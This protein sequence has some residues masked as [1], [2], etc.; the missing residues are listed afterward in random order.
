MSPR[1]SE[2]ASGFELV[3]AAR[4]AEDGTG[5]LFVVEREG[6]IRIIDAN[7]QVL[8]TPFLDI[9][10][11]TES[12]SEYGL[13]GLAFHPQFKQNGYFFVNY[14]EPI[15]P[16]D[17]YHTRISRFTV[18]PNNPNSADVESKLNI[19]TIPQPFGNHNGGDIH[20]GPDG[21]LYIAMGDG[22]GS[23]DP[24]DNAQNPRSVLGKML[25]IDVD[26]PGVR[27]AG[28]CQADISEQNYGIPADNPYILYP[29]SIC[30]EIWSS[31]LR[32]PYRF[33]FDRLTGDLYISDVGQRRLEEVNFE[34][35]SSPGGANYGW[36]CREGST[37]YGQSND[38]GT[39][40]LLCNKATNL[41]DPIVEYAHSNDRCSITGGY[42]YRGP[43]RSFADAYFFADLCTH[44][45]F[46]AR[47]Q[48]NN[49]SF[50]NI[51][52]FNQPITSFG[53]D[54]NGNLYIA[55]YR[56]T[57][58]KLVDD[59]GLIFFSDFDR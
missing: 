56:G 8:P 39:P 31:G 23:G 54:R 40:S 32:N 58:L 37:D 36:D 45:I 44:E 1:L 3:T 15:E 42:F 19:L 34:P 29:H 41:T 30:S 17:V 48:Q 10:D 2:I 43:E 27:T 16:P 13:L 25:R 5:R 11:L 6:F 12:V 38:P 35:A 4:S 22:G 14:V 24:Q 7:Q 46:M 20:F 55:N 59:N 28:A 9:D 33:S 57:I 49:W 21:Y 18:N 53:E 26:N 51:L 50:E 47:N 52:T